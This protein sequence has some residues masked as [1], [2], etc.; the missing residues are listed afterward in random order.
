MKE[1]INRIIEDFDFE[2]VH[3]VM[4]TL[5]WCWYSTNGV[6]SVGALVLCAQELLQDVSKMNVGYSIGIG[7]FRAMKINDE[8]DEDE[9]G[10]KLEFILT[11]TVFCVKWLENESK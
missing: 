3:R 6:P 11:S 1:L 8:F 5:N 4:Q 7:G 9:E 10:L 2:K